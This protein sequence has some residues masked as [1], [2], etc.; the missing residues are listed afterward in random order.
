[1]AIKIMLDAG[2]FS[3]Q[4][5]SPC[6]TKPKYYESEMTWKLHLY[7][8]TE[9]E[10]YGFVVG[11]T[12]SDQAKDLEVYQ[13]GLKAKG[14]DMF[15]SL[16][17][18]AAGNYVTSGVDRPI[19]IYPV[20]NNDAQK[21]FAGLIGGVIR[22]VMQTKQN[23]QIYTREYPNRPDQDYYGVIRG[24]VAAGCEMAFIL[25]HGFHTD[26]SCTA[27]L[28]DDENLKRLAVVEA[29]AIANYYKSIGNPINEKNTLYTV[30]VGCFSQK[31]NAEN[32]LN[33]LK[34]AGFTGFI[35]E[36]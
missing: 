17:S 2:H 9:L 12:R 36:V 6:D 28:L 24:A 20:K 33:R 26:P 13:R 32:M 25:E 16:H 35:K 3:K 21:A 34:S 1:M 31:A 30:Q 29:Q 8:K 7:L 4:N 11:T 5:L 22:Q 18:N 19:I 27:W 15:L 14:Y 10:R 23:Y